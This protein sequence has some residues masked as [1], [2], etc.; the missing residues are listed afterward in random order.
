MAD[1]GQQW[2]LFDLVHDIP[3]GDKIG[4]FFIYGTLTLLLNHALEYSFLKFRQF[5]IQKGALLVLLFA[6]TEEFSQIFFP[7][8]TASLMDIIS[9]L[10]GIISFTI[11]VLW[12]RRHKG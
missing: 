11:V 3:N 8:R 10:I 1:S 6:L 9:D 4:H 7:N 2:I 12:W 5:N